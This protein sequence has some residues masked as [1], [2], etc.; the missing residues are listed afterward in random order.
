VSTSSIERNVGSAGQARGGCRSSAGWRRSSGRGRESGRSR[1]PRR[2]TA[3]HRP[4]RQPAAA[5]FANERFE[6]VAI[7]GFDAPPGAGRVGGERRQVP[8]VALERVRRQPALDAQ[9]IQVRF[10][11]RR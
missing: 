4:R 11:E 8:A 1:A 2:P 10:D 6:R 9:V 3:R 7:Q 5:L